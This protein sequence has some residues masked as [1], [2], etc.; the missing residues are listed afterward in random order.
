MNI[1]FSLSHKS[2]N[3]L[4][5]L[6]IETGRDRVRG[7][8]KTITSLF[9]QYCIRSVKCYMGIQINESKW[10]KM[11]DMHRQWNLLHFRKRKRK[12]TFHL[13]YITSFS[14]VY[15]QKVGLIN[16]FLLFFNRFYVYVC[17]KSSI[18]LLYHHNQIYIIHKYKML[19]RH[20]KIWLLCELGDIIFLKC[21]SQVF[22]FS[23][24]LFRFD[25]LIADSR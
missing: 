25:W 20:Q 23:I 11:S 12:K 5:I 13:I 1:G 21:F 15:V 7:L 14:K 18:A 22:S 9:M 2:N 17:I 24:L 10:S 4:T 16:N 3:A 19:C 8:G 6:Y